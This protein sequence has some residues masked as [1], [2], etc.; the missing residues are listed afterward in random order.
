M[1]RMKRILILFLCF[2][3]VF[4]PYANTVNALV[5][6]TQDENKMPILFT[7]VYPNDKSNRTIDGAGENDLYE[8][9]EIYNNSN[10]ELDLNSKYQL[11]YDYISNSK[12][13][14][15]ESVNAEKEVVIPAN[16][17]AVLWIERTTSNITGAAAEV[18]V[19]DFRAYHNIPEDVPV[20]MLK[21]QD[22]LNNKDRGFYI[23][24]KDTDEEVSR[25]HYSSEDVGDGL[26]LH[27]KVPRN[28]TELATFQQ[29]GETSPGI[30]QPEQLVPPVNNEP[31]VDHQPVESI[32]QEK[33][34]KITTKAVD[35]DGDAISINVS[36]KNS[37]MEAYKQ[38]DMEEND[39]EFT[40]TVPSEEVKG[41]TIS[42]FFSVSDAES[43]VKTE[44]YEVT[45]TKPIEEEPTPTE[46]TQPE[47][48][49]KP[50]PSEDPNNTEPNENN[51]FFTEVYPNDKNNKHIDGAG[52]ADLYEFVEVYNKGDEALNFNEYYKIRYD[53][54]SG[55][56]DL[57]VTV[58]DNADDLNV[59]IPAN[60][61]AVL[62]VHRSS[63]S[64]NAAD[65]T[66]ADFREYHG[67]PANIPVFKVR[68]QDGLPNASDRS[69][70]I[71]QKDDSKAIISEIRFTEGDSSDGKSYHTRFPQEG[72]TANPYIRMG[73]PTPGTVEAEQLI[74]SDNNKPS[75]TP[76]KINEI[77][78][79]KDFTVQANVTDIDGD[80]LTV[81]LY[82]R[83]NP[84]G[85]F[86]EVDM[87]PNGDGTYEYTVA[88][89]ELG[90]LVFEYYIEASDGEAIVESEIIDV[91]VKGE[92]SEETP[93][94]LITEMTPNPNGDYRK[95]SGNHYEYMEI[96][97]NS[98]EIL[99]LNGHTLFYLYP[100]D[101]AA[102]KKWTI[103]QDTA[104]E[105]HSTA[106]I[107]FAKEA[108]RDGYA[109]VEDFN[110]HYNTDIDESDVIVFDNADSSDF[111]LPNSLNRGFAFSSSDSLDDM[112]V[113]AWYDASTNGPDRMIHD[114]RN[115]SVRYHY[116]E[117]GKAMERLDTRAHS[118]PGNLDAGQVPELENQD[119]VAPTIE[120]DQPFYRIE[121]GKDYQVTISSD[122]ALE[123][124]IL[125]YGSAEEQ[126][127][128]YTNE[129][130]MELVK[131]TDGTYTYAADLNINALGRH[132]YM[133]V[134]EDASGN[135]TKVP[136]NSRG[137]PLTVIE[138][139]VS[140]DLPEPG[141][142]LTQEEMV[143]GKVSFYAYG[144]N[145][146]D[147]ANVIFGGD[148]LTGVKAL[149]GPVELNFQGGGIDF[150]YQASA[151]AINAN[152]E[153]DYFTRIIPSYVDGAW[154]TYDLSQSYFVADEK[155]S[156]H[157]GSEN[158][159]YDL[160]VHEE[161][162]NKTNFDD[163]NVVNLHLVLPDGSVIKPD[164]VKSYLGNLNQTEQLYRDNVSYVFGD[165]GA[166]TNTNLNKPMKSDFI[167]NI[168][169]EK[170]TATYYE[171]DTSNYQDGIYE[172]SLKQN[173][174]QTETVNITVDNTKPVING[175]EDGLGNVYTNGSTL[176]GDIHLS[177]DAE[178]NLSGV[179][180][181]E[182]FLD[183][184]KVEYPFESTTAD[185][186]AG[187]YELEVHVYD[188]AGNVTSD[189]TTFGVDPEKPEN[190]REPAPNDFDKDVEDNTTL[191]AKVT[192][193]SGDDMDVTF[194]E[195]KKYDFAGEEAIEGYTYVADREPPL[196]N[197]P[198]GETVLSD[199]DKEKIAFEDGE[200]LAND[201][202]SGFPYHR[203][204][205]EVYEELTEGDT[206]EVYWKGKTFPNR[207]VTM[208][209][210]DY[211]NEEWI[212]QTSSTGDGAESD[213]TL[214]AEVDKERFIRDGKIQAMIQ[215]EV[216]DPNAPFSML[217]MTDT[218]YYAESYPYIWDGLG[219]WTVEEYQNG[220]FEYM[221]HTGD[222]VNVADSDEQW[223]VAN[224][225]L[226][227]FDDANVPYGVLA[228]NHDA[229]IDGV[230][231]SYYHK[232]VGADR[233]EDNPWY[234]GSMDN[235]RNHYDLLSFGGHDFI[236]LYLGFGT[237]DTPETI[238]WA[239][240]VLEKH[241]DRNAILGMHAYLEY[242]ATL[243]NMSQTVFD[244]IIVPNE[245][246]K[247]VLGGHY[248]GVTKRISEIPNEDGTTRQVL[249][250]L[251]DYQGGPNGGDGY[252]RYLDFN[253]TAGTVSINTYS[254]ILDDYH[255]FDPEDEEF[256]V[257]F[258]FTD[259]NKRVATDYFSVNVYQDEVI[260]VDKDV[261]SGDI[262]ST[263]WSG[264]Q[265]NETYYWYMD[266]TDEY[267]STRR[268]EIFRFTTADFEP[269]EDPALPEVPDE[270]DGNQEPE[271][272]DTDD[273]QP[274]TPQP[275]GDNGA[276]IEKPGENNDN[277]TDNTNK[278]PIDK[279]EENPKKVDKDNNTSPNQDNDNAQ[280]PPVNTD[281]DGNELPNTATT[282]FNWLLAGFVLL[283]SGSLIL[284]IRRKRV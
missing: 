274:N 151:S 39:G 8:F 277:N 37:E 19:D 134:T 259:I 28:G 269:V 51:F 99:N 115:S 160:D 86:S 200:Y 59:T 11:R 204:E 31:T 264:L 211:Q 183:G 258:Q 219:D 210:W 17:P 208:Y 205:V 235:N 49:S 206:V 15:V 252:V 217:W 57:T 75:I 268:S 128:D 226:Q 178:D 215:D 187:T 174:K 148:V 20:Y 91:N 181:V 46:P 45:V 108:I 167:F 79:T 34:F 38:G 100:N 240:E 62:W 23:K 251:A 32:E 80:D 169:E 21:G 144:K 265:P 273:G 82:H 18:T 61:P 30:V 97:N 241:A 227:K 225:N 233:Y 147:E 92:E 72:Y 121:Q 9:V 125:T 138:G 272:P 202:T 171:V 223:E 172:V 278:E 152:E 127:T 161:H 83:S 103:N 52:N 260:G 47:N 221:I 102:P 6:E 230:D 141:L 192:D 236:I 177:V 195:G 188:G 1:F 67:V 74:P 255:F 139:E 42:Y 194:K 157:S 131:N 198:N 170:K 35:V 85:E 78:P 89:K 110:I 155:V 104:I 282:M 262:A 245:N 142:S 283:V 256:T 133:V 168:P 184:Q 165:G 64:G 224:R 216:E 280:N 250:M 237:E 93:R 166:P 65:L 120:H 111:N 201:S 228:G 96:Y 149:P 185:L 271:Q 284:F 247:M 145:G 179:D 254:P 119:I 137:N 70:Y 238:A 98:D 175:F 232:Y 154:Y 143:N 16:S 207:I 176:K 267:N 117:S 229:I 156:I 173:N 22:G 146:M 114:I 71:T 69:F 279:I 276:G 162:F 212:A 164:K 107:W 189:R 10:E 76:K 54:R 29:R 126:L 191:K 13:L 68:E 12:G 193:P 186:D 263:E 109:S 26:S 239:N 248:H 124:A 197:A 243:S 116:P 129:V 190:P 257:D 101:A 253:P 153:R 222:I 159:P 7:E 213:I 246:V 77:D 60:S 58:A 122:E 41:N 180:R 4:T 33:D 163:F 275:G 123:K 36:Y 281:K 94:I 158:V 106:L 105:P 48:P 231:Y 150:I 209:A 214:T 27:T 53:W 43:T 87:T 135:E 73:T 3:I 66:E 84:Y 130:E 242:D 218:Q 266:I 25:V 112:I 182:A 249:E 14:R 234:G 2:F 199:D 40:F 56:K 24:N 270:G 81:K 136:Y 196:T 118:N 90:S 220:Q 63:V 55:T 95:G 44:E 203:F 261:A 88:S 244:E 140:T 50:D 132:R 113:E 5:A